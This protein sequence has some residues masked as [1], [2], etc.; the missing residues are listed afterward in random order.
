MSVLTR[1]IFACLALGALVNPA[2]AGDLLARDNP[3]EPEVFEL[4]GM[5]TPR[6]VSSLAIRMPGK[7][8]RDRAAAFTE[9]YRETFLPGDALSELRFG[10][11]VKTSYGH[12]VQLEQWFAGHKVFGKGL[13]LAEDGLGRIR[14]A[15]NSLAPVGDLKIYRRQADEQQAIASALSAFGAK[16]NR[17]RGKPAV[18]RAWLVSEGTLGLVYLVTVFGERPLGEYTY[19]V[20]GEPPV[21]LYAFLRSPMAQGYA[22]ESNP[23]N[24]DHVLVDLPYLTSDQHLTGEYVTVYNCAGT[25]ECSTREQ[26]AGP[27]LNGDYLI[28]PTGDNDPAEPDDLFVEVQAYYAVNTIHDYFVSIGADPAPLEIEVN[29]PMD[30]PNAQYSEGGPEI[31]MGQ[32]SYLDMAVENDVIFHEYGHHVFGEVASSNPLEMDDYGPVSHGLA[33]NEATADYFSCSALDDPELG[34]YFADVMGQAYFP[35]GWL[36]NVDNELT[37]PDG[38]YGE[39]HDDS[40]IWS[41]FLWDV[42]ELLG[43]QQADELYLDA[44]ATFPATIDY[45]TVTQAYLES[46]ELSL[47]AATMDQ[48]QALVDERGIADCE[49]FIALSRNEHTGFI[50]GRE[51]L[52]GM[53]GNIEFIP[54]ELHYY[55]EVPENA[56]RLTVNWTDR[57]NGVEVALLVREDQRIEHTIQWG[58]PPAL[59]SDY[60]FTL[61]DD[62]DISL[63]SA[64][65]PFEPGHTYYF[66]PA[67]SGDKTGEYLI[68]GY[69]ETIQF[70]G[71]PDGG[72]D[73]GADGGVTDGGDT[74]AT[75][76]GNGDGPPDC[77]EGFDSA[78]DGEKW[79]CVPECKEGYE[80]E[81][82]ED[83]VW[84]CVA[85]SSGCG[86]ATTPRPLGLIALALGL[87]LLLVRRK[88][89]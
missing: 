63:P 47:D 49:R 38:L 33:I 26:L 17:V 89:A 72:T 55:I 13:A 20:A 16:G 52:G 45:P 70:D 12:V 41:G 85:K 1:S 14:M 5:R 48:I 86:C 77:G 60:D 61:E 51:L 75:D 74:A 9:R 68:S 62:I 59:Y 3:A 42:R 54:S 79:V 53:G 39:A 19:I 36:R 34:E 35:E 21:V 25:S 43:Q 57:P 67:N 10:R 78:W 23:Y 18:E 50:W 29:H 81:L 56:T 83:G 11:K 24:A 71:G 87:C 73:G 37:C 64:D 58:F 22:Y 80:P 84:K 76:G 4:P 28:E 65:P 66:Q 82:D 7:S 27:D 88:R 6:I 46:A 32:A 15:V 30:Q 8:A 40:M 31:I 44:M 69:C 2:A